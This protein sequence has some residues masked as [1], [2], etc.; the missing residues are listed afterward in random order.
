[1]TDR[2]LAVWWDDGQVGALVKDRYGDA[3][4][5]YDPAWL[6]APAARPISRSLPLTVEPFDRDRCR[7]FF[8]DVS[9]QAD[10]GQGIAGAL[11]L[12]PEGLTPPRV[13]TGTTTPLDE[14]AFADILDR[15]QRRPLPAGGAGV[16]TGLAQ[17]RLPV[18]LI[19]GRP[20]LPGPGQP[21]THIVKPEPARFPGAVAN[22]AWCMALATRLGLGA[23]PVEARE[24]AGR[25]YLLV[26][27]YD[28]AVRNDRPTR[29]HRE[30]A[31]QALGVAPE[32]RYASEGGPAFRQLF[33]LVRAY[34][35]MPARDL[36]RL[37]DVALFNL[38]I[39]NA[40]APGRNFAFLLDD[41]VR[42]APFHDLLATIAW[43]EPDER[44]AMPIGQ[45]R[46]IEELNDE[47]WTRFA[48]DAGITLP[49]L[50]RRGTALLDAIAREATSSRGDDTLRWRTAVRAAAIRQT[51]AR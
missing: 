12:L 51:L 10:G 46:T 6:A 13:L 21:S 43:P 16:R 50:R 39:G 19:D 17:A 29:L 26:T 3:S 49:F 45:A 38:A 15:L 31:C 2:T 18:V 25:R 14:E 8:G 22:E 23:A 9:A 4:F 20:A 24:A 5:T 42:L 44:S 30:D 36:L 47:A 1:M 48:A 33:D 32:R 11:T 34:V 41:G 37:V 40:D 35:P 7:S 28:R 27:R